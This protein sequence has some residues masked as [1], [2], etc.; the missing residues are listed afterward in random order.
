MP[1][2]RMQPKTKEQARLEIARLLHEALKHDVAALETTDQR[3]KARHL[4][5]ADNRRKSSAALRALLP[6]LPE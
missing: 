5:R 4:M 6:T 3:V 2:P 1:E